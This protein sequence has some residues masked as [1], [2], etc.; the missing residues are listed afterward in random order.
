[1]ESERPGG[2]RVAGRLTLAVPLL[3]V[4]VA[5]A[6]LALATPASAGDPP[7]ANI[8][9]PVNNTQWEV[10][11]PIPF[12]GVLSFDPDKNLTTYPMYFIWDFPTERLEGVDLRTFNYTNFTATGVYTVRLTVIDDEMLEGYDNVTVRIVPQNQDPT[13]V[14]SAPA[15]GSSFFTTDFITFNGA[16]STD[17]E[18][19]PLAYTWF[20]DG[21]SQLGTG[22]SI[23]VKL[24]AGVHAVSL[25]VQDDHGAQA[26]ANV[27]VTVAV[28]TPPRLEDAEVSPDNGSDGGAFTFRVTYVE[29]NGEP[30]ESV[31]LVLDGAFHPL[32]A[33]GNQSPAAGIPYSVTLSPAP[34]VHSFYFL[35]SDG[36]LTNVSSTVD[37][38]T[39]WAPFT[40][41]SGDGLGSLS[42]VVVPP[43]D[44]SLASET[45]GVPLAPQGMVALSAPYAISGQAVNSTDLTV[46][47]SFGY[48]PTA[49]R[50][51]AAVFAVSSNGSAWDGLVGVIDAAGGTAQVTVAIS[52][53]PM[54][55][56][57]FAM[58]LTAP[59]D[60]PPTLLVSYAGTAEPNQTLRFDA[61]GSSD[62]EGASLAL[63][64]RFAGPGMDTGW[65][66]GREVELTFPHPG[67]YAVFLRGEDG[68]GNTAFKNMTVE[69]TEVETPVIQPPNEAVVMASLAVAV[70]V[71]AVLAV[72]WRS[73]TPGPSRTYDD[74]YGRA[75]KERMWDQREYAELFHKY[76]DAP[77]TPG[78]DGGEGPEPGETE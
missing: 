49:R 62:P 19:G 20:L 41:L 22:P 52:S 35:A 70:A 53:L 2:Q 73:R 10:G 78:E 25:R 27:S 72:W 54:T 16:G 24:T 55:L 46:S 40:L 18:G 74:L 8:L 42:A 1:M 66:S 37:G 23:S 13:A 56:Q 63:S 57:V 51:T 44:L 5:V 39:V 48:V 30:A 4:L 38:P 12:S 50:Q 68:A 14:V 21:G 69:I 33:Q 59:Q 47:L 6:L 36:N 65:V 76:A 11:R 67:T 71:S 64:W 43:Q 34:G 32:L 3:L 28:N 45:S 31:V 26:F 60:A 75:Y 17:P 58:P 15:P 7:V 29:D 61:S 77:P 9:S